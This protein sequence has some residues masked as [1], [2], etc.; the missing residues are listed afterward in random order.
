MPFVLRRYISGEWKRWT[1]IVAQNLNNYEITVFATFYDRE[2]GA[3]LLTFSDTI[4]AY[5]SH[6]YNTRH[7]AQVPGGASTFDALGDEFLGSAVISSTEPIVGLST[8]LRE[9]VAGAS[10]GLPYGSGTLVYPVLYRTKGGGQWTGYSAVVVQNLDPD[11]AITVHAQFLNSDGTVGV[12]FDA[13]IP[14]N[15]AHSYNTRLGAQTP[16]GAG[17]YSPLGTSWVGTAIVS[18]TSPDGIVGMVQ[19][20]MKGSG[21][22]YMTNYNPVEQ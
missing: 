17:T 4:P 2:G 11:D 10:Q 20:T 21:Y 13:D 16:G 12:E 19:N 18:T 9:G 7:G 14:A 22:G 8:V 1:Q 15:S 5:S 6:W 3:P